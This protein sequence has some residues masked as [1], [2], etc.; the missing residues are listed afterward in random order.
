MI[1]SIFTVLS[2]SLVAQIIALSALPFLT[3]L[4]DAEAFGKYQIYFSSLSILLMVVAFRYEVALLSARRSKHFE[5]LLKVTLRICLVV[6][7]VVALVML[8]GREAIIRN[9]PELSGVLYVLPFAMLI[10]GIFQM[11]TYLPI[12]NRDYRLIANSKISQ[13]VSYAGAGLAFAFFPIATLGLV[14]ADM[15]GRA[16]AGWAILRGTPGGLSLLSSKIAPKAMKLSLYRFRKYP[17][18]TFPGTLLSALVGAM[19]PIAL[20]G[21]FG[22]A[23]TG[24]YALVERFILLPVGIIAAAIAHVFTGEFAAQ[25]RT[26]KLG[27]NQTF[28]RT[29]LW[30]ATLAIIPGIFGYLAAPWLVPLLF[31]P[32][33]VLAGQLCAVAVPIAFTSFVVGPV[34]MALIVCNRQKVQLMWEIARFSLTLAL[35]IWIYE[36]GIEDPVAVIA[37]Y[38]AS[39]VVAYMLY[40]FLADIVTRQADLA[41][42]VS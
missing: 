1:R 3:R 29:V 22:L 18:I 30:L 7:L 27:L 26:S 35:F 40:L 5:N 6:S 20:F 13:S 21:M 14:F 38:A 39:V 24:Q 4:Y 36:T 11:L 10:G 12:R 28:R 19:I 25:S 42:S 23:V 37:W 16:I 17:F 15:M 31:G 2:G 9:Y 41:K 8:T 33:W 32:Q 34:N